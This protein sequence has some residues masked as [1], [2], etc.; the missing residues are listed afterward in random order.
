ME[1]SPLA[2]VKY[3]KKRMQIEQNFKDIKNR[4]SG[5]GLRQNR[6]QTKERMTML[7]FLACLIIIISWWVGLMVETT[8]RHRGYQANTVKNKRVRSFI[9]LARMVYRHEPELLDWIKFTEIIARVKNTYHTF[10]ELGM[11]C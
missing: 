11:V 5:L 6:S 2:L 8:N 4:E 3:Y 9:H 10:I 1:K 7:W